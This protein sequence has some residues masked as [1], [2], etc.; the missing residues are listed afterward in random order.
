MKETTAMRVAM[1]LPLIALLAACGARKELQPKPG[2]QLPVAPY[3]AKR[4]PTADE[5]LTPNTQAELERSV[6]LRKKSEQ[7]ED[8]PF[9]LPPQD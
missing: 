7:R 9:D 8:D 6:E 3:G 2:V 1:L 5:L 4:Q